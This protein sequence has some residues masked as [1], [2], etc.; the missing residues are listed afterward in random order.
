M[1]PKKNVEWHEIT[2]AHCGKKAWVP[3][4]KTRKYCSYKCY[5]EHNDEV[6]IANHHKDFGFDEPCMGCGKVIKKYGHYRGCSKECLEKIRERQRLN[7]APKKCLNCKNL[8]KTK[9]NY[10]YCNDGCKR[11]YYAVSRWEER[12]RLHP[13]TANCKRCKTKLTDRRQIKFCSKDCRELHQKTEYEAKLKTITKI[14]KRCDGTL[15]NRRHDYCTDR[16]RILY[17]AVFELKTIAIR[18]RK[19]K[20]QM[21]A[22]AELDK[23]FEK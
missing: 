9:K 10:R 13:E 2:C 15:K 20:A 23:Y 16:C 22:Q 5:R 6:K 8:I 7:A 11:E 3:K 4:L 12:K 17:K 1:R 14:C 19:E 18:Q 21:E